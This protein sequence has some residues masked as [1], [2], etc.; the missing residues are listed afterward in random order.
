M[1]E[2][3]AWDA[4]EAEA[5]A[6]YA[7]EGRFIL[8]AYSEFMPP[9]YVVVKPYQPRRAARPSTASAGDGTSIDVTE[10]EQAHE[11]GPGLMR[12]A[13]H[14]LTEVGRLIN[15]AP[16]G[17]SHTLLADNPAWPPE[18]AAAARG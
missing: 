3:C 17:L 7:G 13:R 11:L 15:R 1:D 14:V 8:P 12:I 9:P 18:L 4:L 6:A 5:H 16:H 2:P 10:Y